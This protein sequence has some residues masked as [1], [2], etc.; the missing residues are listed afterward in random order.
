LYYEIVLRQCIS[1][2]TK[3]VTWF[4]LFHNGKSSNSWIVE[5]RIVDRIM[6][7][8]HIILLTYFFIVVIHDKGHLCDLA[9]LVIWN[10]RH[11]FQNEHFVQ[12]IKMFHI[13]FCYGK[14]F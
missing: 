11:M 3:E 10:E 8:Q 2:C 5:I 9:I 7:F 13:Q 1:S 6:Y 14:W 12:Q 4:F